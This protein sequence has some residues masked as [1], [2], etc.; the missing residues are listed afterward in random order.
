M[1]DDVLV[2]E[3]TAGGVPVNWLIGPGL[4]ARRVLV[5]LHGGGYELGSVRSD[6][7]LTLQPDCAR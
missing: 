6:G 3:V 1:P 5:F 7:E 4:D 2:R